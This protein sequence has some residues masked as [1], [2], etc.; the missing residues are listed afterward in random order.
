MIRGPVS[1]TGSV[2]VKRP[3]LLLRSTV[4]I[5]ERA[6]ITEAASEGIALDGTEAVPKGPVGLAILEAHTGWLACGNAG[7]IYCINGS[8]K[9]RAHAKSSGQD[10]NS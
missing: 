1:L 8:R 5:A 10:Q 7:T 4:G 3:R 9:Q 6:V 2:K